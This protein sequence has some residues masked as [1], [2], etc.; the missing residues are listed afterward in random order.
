MEFTM[1]RAVPLISGGAFLATNVENRGESATT[2]IPQKHKNEMSIVA[3]GCRKMKGKII[4][5][6]PDRS[7]AVAAV[8]FIPA[9]SEI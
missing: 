8:R 3:E 6:K 5:H 4:Q 2:I 9:I 1:V 7:K